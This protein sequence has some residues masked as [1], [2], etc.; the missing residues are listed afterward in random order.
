MRFGTQRL[1]IAALLLALAAAGSACTSGSDSS[2]PQPTS[3]SPLYTLDDAIEPGQ[4]RV[5][6][7]SFELVDASRPTSPNGDY[8]GSPVREIP[9]EVWYPA[10]TDPARPD[11]REV[12][13]DRSG[14]PYPLIVF[15]HG[16]SAV[17]TQSSTYTRHLASH[18]YVVVAPRFPLTWLGAPGGPRFRDLIN[19]P[20]D[21]SFVI[22]SILASSSEEGHVLHGIVDGDAIGMTGHSLGGFTTLLSVY[23]P[24]RDERIDAGLPISASGC[25]LDED[26]IDG[27]VRPMMFL[28]GSE[29]LL[30]PREGNRMAYDVA[31]APR[32]WVEIRGG[33]HVR[34]ADFD[35][36][37][38]T[39]AGGV[40]RRVRSETASDSTPETGDAG[41]LARCDMQAEPAGEPTIPLDRQQELL[42][43]FATPFF[44]AYLR[45]NEG[46]KTF[47]TD[48]LP[49]LMRES[50]RYEFDL[51]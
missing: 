6:T 17:P 45:G 13:A 47:L 32:F 34:F 21:V 16:F 31:N 46:A 42:R 40:I 11:G 20:E 19:Q 2:D 38:E 48:S 3:Q 27:I 5:G 36:D 37:D 12:A 14:A 1:A 44:D 41:F 23:G 43:A 51:E 4:Y 18:G 50:A 7:A 49:D 26:S 22:D 10:V 39:V 25:F 24:N 9:I 33:N 15:A 29:D 8:P 28:I 30:V 35:V